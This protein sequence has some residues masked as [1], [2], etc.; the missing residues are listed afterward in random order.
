[1][2]FEARMDATRDYHTK[3]SKS[4]KKKKKGKHHIISLICR[5]LYMTKMNVSMKQNQGHKEQ[6]TGCQGKGDGRVGIRNLRLVDTN[7]YI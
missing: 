1:M 4:E 5:I 6:T 7:W 3:C 2:S